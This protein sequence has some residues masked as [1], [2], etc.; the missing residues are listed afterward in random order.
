MGYHERRRGIL[1]VLSGPS[2][3]GKTTVA[4]RLLE[5]VA[6]LRRSISH[7][8]RALREGE[9]DGV[10]YHFADHGAFRRM[11][12]NGEFI[13][14]AEVHGN[15]Y[16]TSMRNVQDIVERG[17]DDLL[18]V[19]DVQGA[20]ALRRIEARQ[21]SIFLLPPSVEELARRLRGRGSEDE[22]NAKIRLAAAMGEMENMAAFDYLVVN[23]DLDRAVADVTA[24][25][26]AERLKP[27]NR[28]IRIS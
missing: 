26:I 28:S 20:E 3:A 16:G 7:T 24:I 9:T 23:N 5:E 1:F 18:L 27:S 6:R 19:I 21:C 25:I 11:I 8:T 10:D 22:Q 4:Q 17:G 12:E 13:E 2:G 14:W 15:L